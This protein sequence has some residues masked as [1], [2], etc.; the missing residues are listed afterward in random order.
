MGP[1]T[2]IKEM[3][4]KRTMAVMIHLL[5]EEAFERYPKMSNEMF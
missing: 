3:R 2:R 4:E 1:R 5:V